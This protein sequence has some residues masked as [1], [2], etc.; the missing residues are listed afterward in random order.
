MK[1]MHDQIEIGTLDLVFSD[2]NIG[3]YELK[4]VPGLLNPREQNL[5]QLSDYLFKKGK[6]GKEPCHQV[7]EAG[8]FLKDGSNKYT[9]DFSCLE[10]K[11]LPKSDLNGRYRKYTITIVGKRLLEA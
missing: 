4:P 6:Y 10:I 7:L 9:A 3:V 2:M 5:H 11:A 1:L 8:F